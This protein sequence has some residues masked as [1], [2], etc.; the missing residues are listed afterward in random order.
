MYKKNGLS[1]Y[2]TG[3]PYQCPKTTVG[4]FTFI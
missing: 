3:T 2:T 4:L 1:I